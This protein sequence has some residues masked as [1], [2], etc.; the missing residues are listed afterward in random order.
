MP[1][2]RRLAR[3]SRRGRW[4]RAWTTGLIVLAL[5]G[6]SG[7]GRAQA[8]DSS[9]ATQLVIPFLANADKPSDLDYAAAACDVA[10]GGREMS[11][12]FRQLF[13]TPAGF[14][15]TACVIT[16]NSYE[17]TFRR[18]TPTRW[19]SADAPTGI[20]GLVETTTLVDGGQ[21]QWTM[22]TQTVA[23]ANLSRADCRAA[24]AGTP[25]TYTSR[26]VKRPLAC[27]TIQPG[28]IER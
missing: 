17:R 19:T 16:T 22:T 25:E 4:Q 1:A 7:R 26:N 14:D 10:A 21:T 15:A 2:P 23:T 9:G 5:V 12:R 11:C 20:C 27:A 18:D 13:I 24:A 8:I 28:A 6:W 3:N